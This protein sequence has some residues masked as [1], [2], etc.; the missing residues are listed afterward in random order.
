MTNVNRFNFKS[1]LINVMLVKSTVF[2]S[3]GFLKIIAA[4]TL[5]LNPQVL[6]VSITHRFLLPIHPVKSTL[7]NIVLTNQ[8]LDRNLVYN[9]KK[10]SRILNRIPLKQYCY[11]QINKLT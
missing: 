7:T 4:F 10:N 2:F 11:T 3:Q 5:I 9:I 8:V 6:K 1:N